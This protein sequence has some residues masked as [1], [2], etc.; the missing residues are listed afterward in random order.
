MIS[1]FLIWKID[2]NL[3]LWNQKLYMGMFRMERALKVQN[4]EM[5]KAEG[6]TFHEIW[7][8]RIY[9]WVCPWRPLTGY[10]FPSLL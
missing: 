6:I 3:R 5:E 7:G 4:K 8:G 1:Y 2:K 10:S 9:I